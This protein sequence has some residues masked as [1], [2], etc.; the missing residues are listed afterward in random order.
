M[1]ARYNASHFGISVTLDDLSSGLHKV[2]EDILH[3]SLH[4][5]PMDERT[6][7]IQLVRYLAA[8]LNILAE[9]A[10]S[11]R[12]GRPI[13]I[14]RPSNSTPNPM[15]DVLHL[16]LPPIHSSTSSIYDALRTA[17]SMQEQFIH[18]RS[19][20]LSYADID[21]LEELEVRTRTLAFEFLTELVPKIEQIRTRTHH[22][23][24]SPMSRTWSNSTTSSLLDLKQSVGDWSSN[25][26]SPASSSSDSRGW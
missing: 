24:V 7:L 2:N 21:W 11:M 16:Q 20:K 18:V 1:P 8:R 13:S 9:L 6:A 25:D 26:S 23:L 5:L 15:G 10:W 14:P 4:Q 12:S 19:L 22:G 17:A 3:T